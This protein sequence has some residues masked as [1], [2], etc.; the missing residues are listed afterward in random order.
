MNAEDV[1]VIQEE[2]KPAKEWKCQLPFNISDN[3]EFEYV[4]NL[5]IMLEMANIELVV[6]WLK[7]PDNY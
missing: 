4:F 7:L 6:K 2:E 3:P 5:L 1:R